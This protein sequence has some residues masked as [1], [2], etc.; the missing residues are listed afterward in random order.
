M[1]TVSSSRFQLIT[2]VATLELVC[3]SGAVACWLQFKVLSGGTE[4]FLQQLSW[5]SECLL[6]IRVRLQAG[7]CS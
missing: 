2:V 1:V 3:L 4:Q 5:R 6:V 7:V